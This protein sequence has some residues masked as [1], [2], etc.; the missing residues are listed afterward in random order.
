MQL[1]LTFVLVALISYVKAHLSDDK[2]SYVCSTTFH[3]Q[4][5]IPEK[6]KKIQSE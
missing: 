3:A 5:V 2:Y 6:L 1:K 4:Q